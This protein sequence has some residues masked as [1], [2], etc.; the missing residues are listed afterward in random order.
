MWVT[1]SARLFGFWMALFGC[2]H[3]VMGCSAT[4][5]HRAAEPAAGPVTVSAEWSNLDAAVLVGAEQAECS[6]ARTEEV[7]Q[8][9]RRYIAL[10]RDLGRLKG[11]RLV[12]STLVWPDG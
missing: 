7:S 1:Q 11:V 8:R 3:L 5:S 4:G 2:L 10:L 12:A 6:I 9:E